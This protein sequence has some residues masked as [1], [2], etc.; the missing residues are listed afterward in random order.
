MLKGISSKFFCCPGGD[1]LENF[2]RAGGK[3]H[4]YVL[5]KNMR[6]KNSP[7]ELASNE[8]RYIRPD[9]K[10]LES[11]VLVKVSNLN[12]EKNNLIANSV[13]LEEKK[14]ESETPIAL[15][16]K[17]KVSLEA[18][19]RKVIAIVARNL[20]V[21]REDICANSPAWDL[22][23]AP[24][25]ENSDINITEEINNLLF[26]ES[27][28]PKNLRDF[29]AKDFT[30]VLSDLITK[31]YGA[32]VAALACNKI[33]CSQFKNSDKERVGVLMDLNTRLQ[34]AKDLIDVY[35]YQANYPFLDFTMIAKMKLKHTASLR[36]GI[37]PENMSFKHY[38]AI[39]FYVSSNFEL[40]NSYLRGEDK[41]EILDRLTGD[42]VEAVNYMRGFSSNNY[43]LFRGIKVAPSKIIKASEGD[44]YFDKAF[45]STS[46]R[47]DIANFFMSVGSL[48]NSDMAFFVLKGKS[49]ADISKFYLP[50]GDIKIEPAYFY[51]YNNEFDAAI[52]SILKYKEYGAWIDSS[53][54]QRK[55]LDE[56]H[57]QQET[58]F[59]PDTKFRILFKCYDKKAHLFKIV[60]EEDGLKTGQTAG[61][62]DALVDLPLGNSRGDV[63]S[64]NSFNLKRR[65]L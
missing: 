27:L 65:S 29:T 21:L 53:T 44:L 36:L 45:M 51:S 3:K 57:N 14:L 8:Y 7:A 60:L 59:K 24:N 41:H 23:V 40:I 5:P 47:P 56:F 9:A 61:T 48:D 31:H 49:G 18:D 64:I 15:S 1:V 39:S 11:V 54:S 58:L 4:K 30:D 12:A 33:I 25:K 43:M 38:A 2:K 13:I 32:E 62:V 55:R 37:V 6:L 17:I 10:K 22:S 50:F 26:G 20:R 42:I 46:K 28:S 35:R 16:S 63:K 34:A 52:K 19:L